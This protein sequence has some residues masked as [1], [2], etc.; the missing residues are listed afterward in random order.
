MCSPKELEEPDVHWDREI[1]FT[2]ATQSIAK[3]H[4]K[5]ER[6]K[7]RRALLQ[8]LYH[9][10]NFCIGWLAS[11]DGFSEIFDRSFFSL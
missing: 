1:V 11:F 7:N 5:R 10:A 3:K 2:E 4:V 8:N 6:L 9:L